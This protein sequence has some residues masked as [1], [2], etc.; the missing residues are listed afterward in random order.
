MSMFQNGSPVVDLQS[1]NMGFMSWLRF[2]CQVD[3][4]SYPHACINEDL[5]QTSANAMV[6]QGYLEA[7][8]NLVAVDDCWMQPGDNSRDPISHQLVADPQRFP[9]GMK[10]LGDYL[11]E[12]GL[13]FGL[14][15]DVGTITCANYTGSYG[16]EHLDVDTFAEWGVDYLKLDACNLRQKKILPSFIE[17]G[18]AI[19]ELAHQKMMFSCCAPVYLGHNETLKVKQ[20]H[21]YDILYHEA[22]CNTWRNFHFV[23]NSW[24]GLKRVILHWA[25][26][27]QDLQSI[28]HGFNDADM[29][30]AGD[31]VPSL[32]PPV[33]AQLQMGFWAMISS[34]LFI[35]A[36]VR[37]IPPV[38]RKVLLNRHVIAVNQDVSQ[39]R[40]ASCVLGCKGSNYKNTTNSGS[41]DVQVWAKLVRHGQSVVLG[42]FNLNEQHQ[43]SSIS[44]EFELERGR[45]IAQCVDLWNGNSGSS[46]VEE[47]PDICAKGRGQISRH[48]NIQIQRESNNIK[49]LHIQTLGVL[50]TSHRMLRV[51]FFDTLQP[52]HPP[53]QGRTRDKE[54][55]AQ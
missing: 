48:W 42:F 33:Q 16:Y 4:D 30:L 18:T 10:A 12:R 36:D 55:K 2:E 14:Y 28:P 3:C 38:Y 34:P 51:D 13:Q 1:P 9:H 40:Q 15:L 46:K 52:P 53:N 47:L 37:S 20:Q 6:E 23:D 24:P 50:P 5:Y 8:Y 7:G 44:Y 32:L 17:F 49:R 22:G 31:D 25:D 29:L 26:Y 19:Q 41:L 35:G 27:W 11:H 39:Q 43:E 54:P 45:G 21:L